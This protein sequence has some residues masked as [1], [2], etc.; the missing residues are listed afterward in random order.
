MTWTIDGKFSLWIFRT[1]NSVFTLLY[2]LYLSTVRWYLIY[3][4]SFKNTSHVKL[5]Y[6]FYESHTENHIYRYC[7]NVTFNLMAFIQFYHHVD[8]FM[9]IVYKWNFNVSILFKISIAFIQ[10]VSSETAEKM[11]YSLCRSSGARLKTIALVYQITYWI[12]YLM[13]A[14]LCTISC[15]TT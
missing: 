5:V 11:W 13:F 7:K 10:I 2:T 3:S 14:D 9:H 4:S 15:T 12:A 1:I 8:L 6:H